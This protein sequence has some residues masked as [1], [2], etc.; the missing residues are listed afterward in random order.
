MSIRDRASWDGELSSDGSFE[1]EWGLRATISYEGSDVTYGVYSDGSNI[2]SGLIENSY[3]DTDVVND[4]EYTYNV[5]A[6]Y[7][8]GTESDFSYPASARPEPA[9]NHEEGWDDGE[10]DAYF[11][12]GNGSLTMVRYTAVEEGELLKRFKW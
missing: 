7:S 12:T 6:T 1:G 10:L 2:A 8:D 3:V 5:T 4:V 11:D 9:S